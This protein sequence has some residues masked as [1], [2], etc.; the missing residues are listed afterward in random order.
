MIERLFALFVLWLVLV[1][2]GCS[3]NDAA[4][5]KRVIVLGFDGLDHALTTRL[6]DQ[7]KLP[8]LARLAGRGWFQPLQTSVPPQ[9]PVAW[10][11]FITGLDAGGHGIFDFVHRDPE[12]MLPYLSTT[13]TEPPGRMLKLGKWQIPLSGGKITL[14]R[15]GT[16]FWELLEERGI[17]AWIIRMPANFPPSGLAARELSGMGTPDIL[18]TYGT[19]SVFTTSP[20]FVD[21][22][23]KTQVLTAR[24]DSGVFRSQLKGP[25][26]PF[27]A[28]NTTLFAPF[29]AYV[30]ADHP[31]VKIVMGE[32][33]ALLA[34]GEWSEWLPADFDLSIP[35]Q[36][37]HAMVR[38][39]LRR[40]RPELQLYA[41]PVNLDPHDPAMPIASPGGFAD[42]LARANG[43]FYTQGMPE[44]TKALTAGV[45]DRDDFLRQASMTA[46][47]NRRQLQ[48]LLNEFRGGLLFYYFG[49]IDQVSHMLW[50]A[51]DPSH[52]A[53]DSAADA[54]Y[55]H[56][57]ENLYVQ[58][59]S[60]VG[61][62]LARLSDEDV[63]IV[64][65]DHGF[66]SWKRAI[67]LNTFL[68]ERGYL[69]VDHAPAQNEIAYFPGVDWSRTQAYALGLNGLYVNLRGREKL[70]IVPADQRRT[71]MTELSSAL[72]R[73]TDPATGERMIE[74]VHNRDETY[75]DT[76]HADIG[77]DMIVG[78][79][80]GYRGSN[81]SAVGQIT[82]PMVT[83]N[84][85][86][87]SG[88]HAMAHDAVPGILFS[89]APLRRP[90]TSLRELAGAVLA[91]FDIDGFPGNGDGK[92]AR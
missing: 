59:D 58:A 53:H 55:A 5:R 31:V 75:S 20:D 40:V 39:Y 89:S 4:V 50:G 62:T 18:G 14:L 13:R 35:T 3:G 21:D 25:S 36:R 90:V 26:D 43:R 6:L 37:L 84:L 44:D 45:F 24:I 83:D 9:S 66:T 92:R 11:E 77:P 2:A 60:I 19:F 82:R 69:A 8:N 15:H 30:D 42:Q 71:I 64:M 38:F 87:W 67:N 79:A 22:D 57:V 74:R 32:E 47:E 73:L 65:S 70:G 68:E 28:E 72:L 10:S 91:E 12:T 48:W 86:P 51:T 88:D 49:H 52:P 17:P 76:G 56:V 81:E 33:E 63:L 29:T 23:F 46:A 78:Y 85:D 34:E 27:L 41:T 16:P 61:E 7:G 80:K 54:R 1:S